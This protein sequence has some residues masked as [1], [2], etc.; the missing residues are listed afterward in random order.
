AI[1]KSPGGV[2][3]LLGNGAGAFTDTGSPAGTG[4]VPSAIAVGDYD[5]DGADDLA[6]A[7]QS[8]NDVTIR[9][10]AGNGSFP[11]IMSSTVAV[12]MN[13]EALARGDLDG[14]GDEDLAVANRNP[15][16][17]SI[18]QNNGSGTCANAI[19]SPYAVGAG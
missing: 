17:V 5:A 12:Q 15:N 2:A 4:M 18:L 3:I 1:A 8:S 14:D 7:N 11:N 13:P 19:G 6:I 16:S 10:G 9:R